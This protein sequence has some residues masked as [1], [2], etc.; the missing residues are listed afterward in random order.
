MI[1]MQYYTLAVALCFEDASMM[2]TRDLPMRGG[3]LVCNGTSGPGRTPGSVLTAGVVAVVLGME[4]EE[5]AAE[6]PRYP[7]S[8]GTRNEFHA[9]AKEGTEA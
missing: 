8:G 4:V 2:A 7:N 1:Y 5:V 3:A 9:Q 6:T